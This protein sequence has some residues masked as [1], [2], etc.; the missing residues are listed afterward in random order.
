MNNNTIK[1]DIGNE[2]LNERNFSIYNISTRLTP[3]TESSAPPKQLDNK[4]VSNTVGNKTVS[5][6]ASNNT[7]NNYSSISNTTRS[8]LSENTKQSNTKKMKYYSPLNNKKAIGIYKNTKSTTHVDV[9]A[10][11]AM[12]RSGR[13]CPRKTIVVLDVDKK[14]EG[15]LGRTFSV[16]GYRGRDTLNAFKNYGMQTA[17]KS[18]GRGFGDVNIL[19]KI[20]KSKQ[21]RDRG[22]NITNTDMTSRRFHS[23]FR[24]YHDS[25]H[26]VSEI[27]R[28]GI[29]TRTK[30][31]Y[32]TKNN[33]FHK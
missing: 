5:I 25:K 16:L 14:N 19:T 31:Q 32:V 33:K 9:K 3:K 17:N 29:S 18:R 7:M 15:K 10:E 4:T 2:R 11:T 24:N 23:T 1:S 27:P 20:D 13:P 12:Q 26:I 8:I 30:G 22:N 21:T 6:T 28:G